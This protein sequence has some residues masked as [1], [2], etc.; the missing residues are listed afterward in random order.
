MPEK[1]P[2]CDLESL[3]LAEQ[4]MFRQK[5][6]DE[7]AK[8]PEDEAIW[9]TAYAWVRVEGDNPNQPGVAAA[10]PAEEL[11]AMAGAVRHTPQ[12]ERYDLMATRASD[13]RYWF[14][15]IEGFSSDK[16]RG[17]LADMVSSWAKS[18]PFKKALDIGTGVGVSLPI[19]E[20]C[21]DNVVGLDQNLAL[22][23]IAQAR[24]GE[25]TSL[26][27]GSAAELPFE[28]SSFDLIMSQGLR[29]A[30]N[31]DVTEDFLREIARV[32]TPDGVYLEGHYLP[33][34]DG[35][36]HPDLARFT[37]T[38]KGMLADMIGDSV[39]GVHVCT[40]YLNS[41]EEQDF[42]TEVGL[43]QQHY[44]VLGEDGVSHTLVTILNKMPHN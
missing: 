19:L 9:Q 35:S 34:S 7:F 42:L 31:K 22:L 5:L 33:Q 17:A 37:G 15:I 4:T 32:M 28:T 29:T 39:S 24:A 12:S 13:G 30:L 3:P 10:I 6:L 2:T 18:L 14:D 40:D 27:L 8:N 41:D 1:L 20:G 16:V 23:H 38:S 11:I 44:D 21:A 26:V 36:P 43:V 25:Q